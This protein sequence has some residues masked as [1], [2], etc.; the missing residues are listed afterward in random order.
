MTDAGDIAPTAVFPFP[1]HV[2]DD[3]DALARGAARLLLAAAAAV[4]GDRV[5]IALSGGST[6]RRL[7]ELLAG[8]FAAEVPWA[9]LHWFFGDERLVP[10]TDAQSNYR[11]VR[12]AM[13]D[14]APV[15]PE[16]IHPVR[17]EGLTPTEAAW[18]YQ[19]ELE[20]FHESDRLEP[21]RPLFEVVLLG[22]GSDGHTA[23]LFPGPPAA[24]E[25]H[26]WVAGVP[27]AGLEPFVPRVTLTLPAI[28]SSR[29]T[30]FLVSGEGK[31]PVLARIAAGD[32]LP[33]AMVEGENPP[34]WLLDRAAAAD[35]LI[36][37]PPA[38]AAAQPAVLVVM[39]VSGSGK[40]TIASMLAQKLG[41]EYQDGDWFHPQANVDKMAAGHALTDA[42]R[43]PWLAAI[44][45]W[46]ETT[47]LAGRHGVVACS[48]LH[49]SYRDVLVGGHPDAVRIVFLDGSKELIAA[50]LSLRSGHFMPAALLDSQ[51]A[52]LE[53]P[54]ADERPITVTIDDHPAD[55]VEAVVALLDADLAGAVGGRT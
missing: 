28:A 51:F 10:P 36:P 33:A 55:M 21:G 26:A 41:W 49:R 5:A 39:G 18:L 1:A 7:Y 8:E 16:N 11:M 24:D 46:I 47:R 42:D 4:P 30:L 27:Q 3:A 37:E 23:S 2:Y 38:P 32:T 34:L 19:L 13:F 45:Q 54:T 15:P 6:P 48:A 31:R 25:R 20:R 53:P 43:G 50:R 14:H 35:L 9:R 40:S 22:L 29:L 12:E 17:T 44:A 52:A